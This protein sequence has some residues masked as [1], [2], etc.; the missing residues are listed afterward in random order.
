MNLVWNNFKSLPKFLITKVVF[1][2]ILLQWLMK[3]RVS[4]STTEN[5]EEYFLNK[6]DGK[7]NCSWCEMCVSKRFNIF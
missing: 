6:F 5:I 1:K 4:H 2:P 7:L 3:V